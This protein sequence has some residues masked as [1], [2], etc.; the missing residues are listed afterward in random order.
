MILLL[1]ASGYMGGAF[2]EALR[3]RGWAYRACA[4]SEADYTRFDVLLGLLR[5]ERPEL[6]VSA[7]GFTGRPN[8]DAC[9]EARAETLAGNVLFLQT[10]AHACRVVEVP[11]GHVSSGCIYAGAKVEEGGVLR[12]ERDLMKAG[13]REGWES[14]RM[15][16]RGFTEEDEPNFSFHRPP[17]SFYSGSKALGEEAVRGLGGGYLWRLRI[18]FDGV[19]HPKN[20][21]SK[22]LTYPKLY[23]NVN[24]I[25][26]RG[27][28][29]RACLDLWGVRAPFGVYNVT[30][31]G[32]V[33]T[34]QVVGLIQEVWRSD[35][36]FEFWQSD[37]EFYRLAAR[38]PRSNCVLDEGKL[39]GAGVRV[40]P[41]T[42][43]LRDSLE[44][45]VPAG[46]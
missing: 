28:F 35:R 32:W 15:I 27:D 24:S 17:C 31:P 42:E 23:D 18:P 33:T 7:A 3:E 10:L 11:W 13:L 12:V 25:S 29:A 20:Y 37:E 5:R 44:R 4:R 22:L 14:G 8:V 26:H 34:R 38:A 16:L 46:G 1:G 43:A 6:V 45:W 21:L 40:R 41:V 39:V 19:D 36:R 9:E 2:A 30:N